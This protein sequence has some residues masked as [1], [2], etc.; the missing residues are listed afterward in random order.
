MKWKTIRWFTMKTTTRRRMITI[1]Q[2]GECLGARPHHSRSNAPVDERTQRL[3]LL[4]H[5]ALQRAL[6]MAHETS[7][8]MD[9]QLA[10][11]D[12]C[13]QLMVCAHAVTQTRTAYTCTRT[14]TAGVCAG[15]VVWRARA[16]RQ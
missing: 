5:E 12:T 4:Y 8:H 15:G 2:T 10:C 3:L 13:K 11:V 7:A 9:A 6:L 1:G 14:P 16:G